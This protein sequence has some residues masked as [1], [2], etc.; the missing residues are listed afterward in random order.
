[1]AIII[2]KKKKPTTYPDWIFDG[3][4]IEDPHGYGDRAV[5]FLRAL[6]HPKNPLPGHAFQLDD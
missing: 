1:M 4:K 5:K 6:K 2:K 3:S